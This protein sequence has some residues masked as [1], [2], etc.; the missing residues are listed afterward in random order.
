M[1]E[2]TADTTGMG[3]LRLLEAIRDGDWPIRFYQAGS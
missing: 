3:T 1:P 2:F